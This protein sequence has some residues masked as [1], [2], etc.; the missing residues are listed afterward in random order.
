[1][2][3]KYHEIMSRVQVTPQMHDR[4]M[5]KIMDMDFDEKQDKWKFL[6]FDK[7]N[8]YVAACFVFLF[9]IV[10]TM[11]NK[12]DLDTESPQ[13][14]THD[15]REHLSVK[16]LSSNVGYRVKE[17]ENIPFKVDKTTYFSYWGNMAET[18]YSGENKVVVFRMTKGDEDVS[19]NYNVFNDVK[20]VHAG[21][22]NVTIKGNNGLYNLAT[23]QFNRFSYS[24]EID[25]A[26]TES[27]MLK[28]VQSVH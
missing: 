14:A 1:M 16:E 12:L 22:Y 26:I 4:I 6:N 2:R 23:W 8:L 24:L 19:G 17:V 11:I 25:H 21:S 5:R 18:I 7:R 27:E 10:F 13:L 3:N 20:N 15:V 9:A 28:M